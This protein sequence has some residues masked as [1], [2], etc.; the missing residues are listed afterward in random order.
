M[1]QQNLHLGDVAVGL[2]LGIEQSPKLKLLS[3]R[4]GRSIGEVHNALVRLRAARLLKPDGRVLERE[5]FLRFL[6]WGVPHAFPATVGPI[7]V[8]IATARLPDAPGSSE[9]TESEF[10]WPSATGVSRGQ[11]L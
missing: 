3:E 2:A 1:K 7:T 5:P 4:T 8:G 10:V 9:P 6:R 11:A